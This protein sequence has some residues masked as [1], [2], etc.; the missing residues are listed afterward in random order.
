MADTFG[1]Q[2][3]DGGSGKRPAPTIEGTATEVVIDRPPGETVS[4]DTDAEA[5]RSDAED[6]TEL[7]EVRWD[8]GDDGVWDTAWSTTKNVTHEY[9]APGTYT[10]RLEVRDTGGLTNDTTRPAVVG[11]GGPGF[12]TWALYAVLAAVPLA[13]AGI[14]IIWWRMRKPRPP[15]AAPPTE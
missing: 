11:G 15:N 8:W 13:V 9:R 2:Q 1:D 4:P 5:A 6:V 7:L 10:I 12:P 14:L 3:K